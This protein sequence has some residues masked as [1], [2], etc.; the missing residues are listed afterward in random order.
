MI[1]MAYDEDAKRFV[2]PSKTFL[3]LFAVFALLEAGCEMGYRLL[4]Q[5]S[6]RASLRRPT[7]PR[8]HGPKVPKT[9]REKST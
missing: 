6:R 9:L 8:D 5:L 4:R 7:L 1:S 2:S 3:S